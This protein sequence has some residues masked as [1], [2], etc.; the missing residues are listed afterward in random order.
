MEYLG[1]ARYKKGAVLLFL[2]DDPENTIK[3]GP[4]SIMN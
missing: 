2:V 4:V 3:L 1:G